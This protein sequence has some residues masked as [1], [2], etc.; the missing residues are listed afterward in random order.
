[1]E[2]GPRKALQRV[3]G[4]A[5]ELS[6]LGQRYWNVPIIIAIESQKIFIVTEKEKIVYPMRKLA[7]SEEGQDSR[8][9][10]DGL[11]LRVDQSLMRR[12]LSRDSDSNHET[13][14]RKHAKEVKLEKAREVPTEAEVEENEAEPTEAEVE[15]TEEA[16]T[17]DVCDGTIPGQASSGR[18]RQV[19]AEPPEIEVE[20]KKA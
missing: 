11:R 2:G 20:E 10:G 6:Y 17:A 18:T 4:I 3:D 1:M 14:R 15:E 13:P 19:E 5:K 8:L 7:Y 12:L 9:I 16:G